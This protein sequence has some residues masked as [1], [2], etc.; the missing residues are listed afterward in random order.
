MQARAHKR[1]DQHIY[2]RGKRKQTTPPDLQTPANRTDI[3][4]RVYKYRRTH[5]H[6]HTCVQA[7]V[8][9]HTNTHT[10]TCVHACVHTYVEQM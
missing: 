9:T 3:E 2:T 4:I 6:T 5:T 10:H 1:R 8:R 7:Y